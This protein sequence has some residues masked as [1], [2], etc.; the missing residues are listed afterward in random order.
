MHV[1]MSL[2]GISRIGYKQNITHIIDQPYNNKTMNFE[3]NTKTIQ[4]KQNIYN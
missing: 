2:C 3:L 1:Y 4:T